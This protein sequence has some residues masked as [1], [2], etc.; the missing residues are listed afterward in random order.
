MLDWR[1][2]S[3]SLSLSHLFNMQYERY[4][5]VKKLIPV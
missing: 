4:N 5:I 2:L 3:L 1:A